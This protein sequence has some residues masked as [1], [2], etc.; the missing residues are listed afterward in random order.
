[1]NAEGSSVLDLHDAGP[2]AGQERKAGRR[3]RDEHIPVLA[4]DLI[5]ELLDGPPEQTAAE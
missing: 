2:P 4:D 1:M 3:A 5:L